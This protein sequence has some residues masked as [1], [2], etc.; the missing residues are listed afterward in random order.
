[1]KSAHTKKSANQPASFPAL[2]LLRLSAACL[3]AMAQM[4]QIAQAQTVA[5]KD[6][7]KKRQA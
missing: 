5:N 2:P 3:M 7:N 4:T 6:E 1:M